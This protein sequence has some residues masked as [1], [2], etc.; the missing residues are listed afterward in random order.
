MGRTNEVCQIRVVHEEAVEKA[1]AALP[2]GEVLLGASVLLKALSDPTRIKILSALRETELCVC[3][4]A[5]A[6]GMSESAVSHQ[7]RLLRTTRLVAY[8]KEGRQVY[9]RLADQHV[10]AIL[11]CALEHAR[12]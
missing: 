11:D 6:L 9:Y 1:K 5:A 4:L 7:L 2:K 10:E 12:E 8:R 3:D